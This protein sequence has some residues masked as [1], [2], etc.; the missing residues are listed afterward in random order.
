VEPTTT[1]EPTT[2]TTTTTPCP[3]DPNNPCP[4][5]PN[6]DP[7][8][9]RLVNGMITSTLLNPISEPAFNN[10]RYYYIVVDCIKLSVID[11]VAQLLEDL[12]LALVTLQ[13]A[14]K[15][16][17]ELVQLNVRLVNSVRTA[18]ERPFPGQPSRSYFMGE[19]NYNLDLIVNA[20]AGI[21]SIE[22]NIS[23]IQSAIGA[24]SFAD[25]TPEMR[26]AFYADKTHTYKQAITASFDPKNVEG[27]PFFGKITFETT[28]PR[29][30][31]YLDAN[32]SRIDR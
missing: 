26:Q 10:R 16:K 21:T 32:T 17:T 1:F 15:Y 31:W 19:R 3:P 9:K 8:C 20:Q 29:I 12:R 25:W 24:A 11:N 4:G 7:K 28:E 23:S 2:T 13:E 14:N 27:S 5:D 6:S 22:A 30:P 18:P